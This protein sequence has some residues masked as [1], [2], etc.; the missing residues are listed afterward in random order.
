VGRGK[1]RREGERE[2][3]SGQ[4]EPKNGQDV[5]RRGPRAEPR[6]Q[7]KPRMGE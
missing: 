6:D 4:D 1:L 2:R 5:P 7:E 3:P